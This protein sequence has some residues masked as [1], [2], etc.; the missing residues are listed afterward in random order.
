MALWWLLLVMCA[1]GSGRA[2]AVHCV[3]NNNCEIKH[4]EEH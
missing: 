4:A 2:A 3:F 1:A